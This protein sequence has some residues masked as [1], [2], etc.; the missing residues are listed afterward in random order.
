LRGAGRE[1][2]LAPWREAEKL[3]RDSELMLEREAEV[4]VAR[5][6]NAYW[7]LVGAIEA[8][9]LQRKSVEVAR[10]LLTIVRARLEGGRGI[11]VDVTEALAGLAQREVELIA[12]EN[13]VANQADRL[14]E[15]I[16][17]FDGERPDL[18]LEVVPTDSPATNPSELPAPPTLPQLE[19]AF[20]RRTDL[21]AAQVRIEAATLEEA[22]AED[23]TLPQLDAVLQGGLRGRGS[24]MHESWDKIGDRI[25]YA[26][27]AT[28][29]LS[30]PLGNMAAAA[31]FAR[32]RLDRLRR[33]REAASLR[34]AAVREVRE[35]CRNVRS[36]ADRIEAARRSSAA[37]REQLDAE[38]SRLDTGKS[39]P[40][41]VLQA[42]EDA[43]R[44][45]AAEVRARVDYE[46]SRVDLEA[47]A[48]TLLASRGLT[49]AMD[50][51]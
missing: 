30:V 44:A 32:A 12:A 10:E 21:R 7:N 48:G 46:R 37:A 6:E 20:G 29:E 22:R 39:T 13:F 23:D 40:F 19:A 15:E 8:R 42:E 51:P 43:R 49:A 3:T 5:A 4:T 2:Q 36:A 28:L 45:A 38:R 25:E 11:P 16:L 41:D 35:A 33:E 17:P 18:D 27:D 50:R 24:G 9:E 26:W 14:R 47:A 34:N 31:R 1:V